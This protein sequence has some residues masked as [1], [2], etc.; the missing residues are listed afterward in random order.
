MLKVS[1]IIPVYNV[2]AYIERCIK[3]V[4]AQTYTNIECILVDD[5]TPDDSIDICKK[6]IGKYAGPIIFKIL[7]HKKNRGL[8]AAR[9]TGTEAAKG[10]Y[11]YYLDSDDE[12]TPE[13]ID[14]LI[15]AVK[16]HP[17][18]ELVQGKIK[19]LPHIEFYNRDI[20]E[21]IDY[22]D[23]NLWIRRH[24]YKLGNQ[25]PLNAWDKLVK[26][27]FI[28]THSLYFKEGLIHEDQLWMFFVVKYLAK[29]AVVHH[30]T[31]IHYCGTE[32]SIMSTSTKER[33][34]YHWSVIFNVAVDNL[35]Y[36]L[37]NQ[38]LL[39]YLFYMINYYGCR[40]KVSYG[41]LLKKYKKVVFHQRYY[42]LYL[43]LIMLQ[44]FYPFTRG[45]G[46]RR[47]IYHIIR[48]EMNNLESYDT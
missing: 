33:T 2:S 11:I 26:R 9:N 23:D 12:I 47:I 1:I 32:G 48:K 3:S 22:I 36:P 27:S 16:K 18:V 7:H 10:E 37:Y 31:Y 42:I 39:L 30:T 15:D 46:I 40:G 25:I 38:Q 28:E 19:A 17:E 35:D 13:C 41:E 5:V 29:Y 43:S 44:V 34:S 4:M 20:I 21:D 8:S 24:F 14:I 6:M 45:K